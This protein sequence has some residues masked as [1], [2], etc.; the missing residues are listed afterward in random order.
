MEA[1]CDTLV[2][3]EAIRLHLSIQLKLL[4]L[5][6]YL[7]EVEIGGMIF[8]YSAFRLSEGIVNV[9]RITVSRGKR[10]EKAARD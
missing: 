8:E 3:E 4:S 1:D 10:T 2:V 9:G 5:G 6:L 7:G